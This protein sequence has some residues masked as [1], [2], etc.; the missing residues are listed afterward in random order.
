MDRSLTEDTRQQIIM[1]LNNILNHPATTML[2]HDVLAAR[3]LEITTK[4]PLNAICD[5]TAL[6]GIDDGN[7]EAFR[8]Y[9]IPRLTILKQ[10]YAE[11]NGHAMKDE[12]LKKALP[13]LINK[14]LNV[15]TDSTEEDKELESL[16][17]N[18]SISAPSVR[19]N[20]GTL[21]HRNN[22]EQP[23]LQFISLCTESKNIISSV[24]I[25]NS[26]CRWCLQNGAEQCSAPT[27]TKYLR[28]SERK[29]TESVSEKGRSQGWYLTPP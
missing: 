22:K 20:N 13:S 9:A 16:V 14:F 15:P 1:F 4:T 18:L 28:D 23:I 29:H 21:R 10:R 25:Y 5:A 26:Y 24:D 2:V 11:K 19:I 12:E 3:G 6:T 7:R 27:L 8:N 17:G